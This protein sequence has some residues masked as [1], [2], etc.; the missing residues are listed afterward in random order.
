MEFI[1][2][3]FKGLIAL[4]I[5]FQLILSVITYHPD[6][7]AFVLASKFIN[8]GEVFTF[9]DHVSKLPAGDTIKKIYGDDIFIY[10]PLSYLIPSAFYAPFAPFIKNVY[11]QVIFNDELVYRSNFAFLPLI[12]FKLPSIIFSLLILFFLPKLFSQKEHGQIAQLIWAFLP[13]NLLVSAGM[14]QV[15]TILTL[16]ILLSLI[17]IKEEKLSQAAIF[18]ALSALIKPTGLVLL[19]LIFVYS[20]VQDGLLKSIKTILPAVLTWGIISAPFILSPGYRMYALMAN[21]TGKTI[22]AGIQIA[23]ATQIPWFFIAYSYIL[24]RLLHQKISLIS[25]IGLTILSVLAFNHF[26]PQWFL[27]VVPFILFQTIKHKQYL[28][29]S[30]LI[31]SWMLIW[32]SFEPSLHLGMILSL[33]SSFPP[34]MANPLADSTIVLLARSFLLGTLFYLL[35]EKNEAK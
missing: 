10:P 18:I 4:G 34:T 8:Q 2:R 6:L 20:L 13:T 25:S 3:H 11:D 28:L 31:I 30:G 29:L 19:P 27:W 24:I 22:Y 16:F 35:S 17:K 23:G 5:T 9:Y 32:L 7:R 21:L 14:G 12:I 26:H 15:D 33:K 1:K